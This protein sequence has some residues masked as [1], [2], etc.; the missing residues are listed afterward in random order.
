MEIDFCNLKELNLSV[1]RAD[2]CGLCL[3]VQSLHRNLQA[4]KHFFE[5][6]DLS[7]HRK[8]LELHELTF[9]AILGHFSA[10]ARVDCHVK[11]ARSIG[12]PMI[13]FGKAKF[14]FMIQVKCS[15]PI[16]MAKNTGKLL[17]ESMDFTLCLQK[18][19]QKHKLQLARKIQR[20][21]K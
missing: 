11:Y 18:T 21:K 20:L 19:I 2:F 7:I 5:W 16:F 13:I 15:N 6:E 4:Q 3:I 9:T 17:I 1:R 10:A 12:K 14:L 8:E